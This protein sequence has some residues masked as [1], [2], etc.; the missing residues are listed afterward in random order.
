V[1][2]TCLLCCS[3]LGGTCSYESFV[4]YS[5][6]M[7]TR[8]RAILPNHYTYTHTHTHTPQH[9][10]HQW[11]IKLEHFNLLA[12]LGYFISDHNGII[13]LIH[14]ERNYIELYM[15][16]NLKPE[17]KHTSNLN[18]LLVISALLQWNTWADNFMKAKDLLSSQFGLCNVI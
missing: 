1:N 15:Q 10:K 17:K 16:N 2:Y 13:S 7:T 3:D 12:F 8:R 11:Y 6:W 4:S 14:Q 9:I 18:G 5:S